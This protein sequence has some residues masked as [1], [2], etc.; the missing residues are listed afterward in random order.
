MRIIDEEYH[1]FV[2]SYSTFSYI[3]LVEVDADCPFNFNY[4][5]VFYIYC[6]RKLLYSYIRGGWLAG[7]EIMRL[8]GNLCLTASY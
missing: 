2:L 6:S 4:S 1:H 3:V 5:L 8:A 7:R